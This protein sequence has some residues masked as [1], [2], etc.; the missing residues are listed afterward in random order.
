VHRSPSEA[1]PYVW[2]D[3]E[4]ALELHIARVVEDLSGDGRI[5]ATMALDL[6][7]LRH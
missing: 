2:N 3:D 1:R 6:S 4:Q 7:A 5:A